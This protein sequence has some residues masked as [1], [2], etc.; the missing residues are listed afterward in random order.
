MGAVPQ[1]RRDRIKCPRHIP[2]APSPHA[3]AFFSCSEQPL[4]QAGTRT[5]TS[6]GQVNLV[7]SL[8]PAETAQPQ[9]I[10][11]QHPRLLH[12]TKT[13]TGSKFFPRHEN[14]RHIW[15]ANPEP[16]A[17]ERASGASASA[18]A[19]PLPSHEEDHGLPAA[20][21]ARQ[22]IVA[23]HELAPGTA[24]FYD[25]EHEAEVLHVIYE[26]GALRVQLKLP[27]GKKLW[28]NASAVKQA[29]A[30]EVCDFEGCE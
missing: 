8:K 5:H 11:Q 6:A 27:D 17:A 12:G 14:T 7:L 30:A 22:R 3:G 28:R 29:G 2:R 13:G 18:D 25:G 4:S 10:H 1:H 23:T 21:R 9:P 26:A 16:A 19:S 20:E 15:D 24:V